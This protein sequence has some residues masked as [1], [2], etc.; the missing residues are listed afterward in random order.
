MGSGFCSIKEAATRLGKTERT[1]YNLIKEGRIRKKIVEG[2]TLLDL[3]DVE[4][5]AVDS[6]EDGPPL[7]R[8]T[9]YRMQSQIQ[10]LQDQVHALMHSLGLRDAPPLRPDTVSCAGLI[11]AVQQYLFVEDREKVWTPGFV[12]QW[13]GILERMDEET[14]AAITKT[15]NDQQAWVPFFKFCA[16]LADFCWENDKKTPSLAWQALAGKLETA[17]KNMRGA[18]V[19]WVEMGRGTIPPHILEALGSNRE[20]LVARLAK[21]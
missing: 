9:F 13:A 16:E 20:A 17:R 3:E 2:R 19:T 11:Q 4:L 7:N 14:F 1:V 6:G 10:K 15:A 8:K 21:G 5:A 18:V 12:E